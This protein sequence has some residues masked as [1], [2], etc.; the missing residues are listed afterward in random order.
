MRVTLFIPCFIDSLYPK[1]AM[2]IVQ[3]LE[4]LGHEVDYPDGQ[5]CC[6]QPPFNSGYWDDSGAAPVLYSVVADRAPRKLA[7][8]P[9]PKPI[10]ASFVR[11]RSQ[12]V[13]MANEPS[14]DQVIS[15]WD[16]TDPAHPRH[17]A[18]RRYAGF[19]DGSAATA[20]GTAI[21]YWTTEGVRLWRPESGADTLLLPEASRHV[22]GGSAEI[23]GA[24]F[25]PDGSVLAL[26]TAERV[27]LWSAPSTGQAALLAVVRGHFDGT[28]IGRGRPILAAG[29]GAYVNLWDLDR[30]ITTLRNPV[31]EA[32]HLV[33]G[34]T[35]AEWPRYIKDLTYTPA[36]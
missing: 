3:I 21:A 26:S 11:G 16:L 15:L 33:G 2:S 18:S 1:V 25:S 6:G 28:G 29:D 4:R 12:L 27:E 5:T 14:Q 32:C 7:S 34:L 22:L 31:R 36:C 35:E 8:I 30:T 23:Q 19:G 10:S 17:V 13:V 20:D 9:M 24:A